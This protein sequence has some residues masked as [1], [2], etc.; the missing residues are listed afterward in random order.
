VKELPAIFQDGERTYFADTCEPLK[1]A[2]SKAEVHLHAWGHA[3]YPGVQ[4]P[5]GYL[6]AVRSIGIWDAPV[7][8]SWGL[9]LHCNEGIEFTYLRRGKTA[10]EVDGKHWTLR[11]GCLTITRPWQFHRV[12][13]PSTVKLNRFGRAHVLA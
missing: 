2:A 7:A 13:A 11:K 8:Q 4:L 3:L 5:R 9:D 12:G 1:E 10:F 6:P